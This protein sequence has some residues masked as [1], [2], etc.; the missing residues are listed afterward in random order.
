MRDDRLREILS[1]GPGAEETGARS[2]RAR[3]RAIAQYEAKPRRSIWR[4]ALA[5]GLAMLLAGVWAVHK[6]A[7]PDGPGAATEGQRIEMKLQLSDGTRV[8]W[9]MDDRYAL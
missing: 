9:V 7:D 4:P 6:P 2:A 5:A 8:N 3:K 1:V